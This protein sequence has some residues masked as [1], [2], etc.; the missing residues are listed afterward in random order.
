MFQPD[1]TDNLFANATLLAQLC[2]ASYLSDPSDHSSFESLS[3]DYL[4][5]FS[6]GSTFGFLATG[7]AHIAL[8]FRGTDSTEELV[9]SMDY[10]QSDGFGGKVHREFGLTLFEVLPQ[11]KSLLE[12]RYHDQHIWVTGHSL[13]G[14]LA[15]LAAKLIIKATPNTTVFTFGQ[16]RVG[17]PLF[18]ESYGPKHYRF[19][20]E[21]DVVPKVPLRG[22]FTRYRHVGQEIIL[23]E[24]QHR[25]G[26]GD[27]RLLDDRFLQLL[28]G[29]VGLSE[30]ALEEFISDGIREH[31]LAT[32]ISRCER[33]S[34]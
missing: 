18:A 22:I 8:T 9:R 11:I 24:T 21:K 29:Q 16:P 23:G 28:A 26:E 2:Q 12:R 27:T 25:L 1:S 3:L 17:D 19:V 15:T 34:A 33:H 13:G 4:D 7:K 32:Y 6:H 5:T 30:I 10:S 31:Q 20:T 14:A